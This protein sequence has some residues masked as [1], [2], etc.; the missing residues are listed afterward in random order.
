[1]SPM[2]V[3]SFPHLIAAWNF[4]ESSDR[5]TATIGAP[6][7]LVSQRGPLSVIADKDAWGQTALHLPEG[8]WLSV[9]AKQAP[10]L[11]P[12][13]ETGQLTLTAWVKRSPSSHD[14]CE[15]VAGR[16]NETQ[17]G[18]QYGLFL[19]IVCGAS[20]IRVSHMFLLL[21][22]LP[23]A[24]GIVWTAHRVDLSLL[25]ATGPV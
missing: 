24:L 19:N 22:A 9:T 8:Q 18:R 14:Q 25:M 23:P 17:G 12:H 6:Y 7:E 20:D 1:M 21:E 16:W 5:F 3:S 10:R 13:A 11:R 4:T 2:Q 15:F